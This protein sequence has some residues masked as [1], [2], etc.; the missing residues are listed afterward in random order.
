MNASLNASLNDTS[1]SFQ[2]VPVWLR[3]IHGVV[4]S[5]LMLAAVIGNSLVLFL[6]LHNKTLQHRSVMCSLGLVVAD[7]LIAVAWST[8]TLGNIGLD[9]CP[10]GPIGCSILGVLT[11]IGVYARWCTVALITLERFLSIVFP[12]WYLKRS[13][14]VLVVLTIICWL[15]PIASTT[16]PWLAGLGSYAFR[17]QYSSCI[18]TCSE[19]DHLCFRFYLSLYGIYIGV[20]GVLPMILYLLMCVIGQRKLYKMKHIELGTHKNGTSRGGGK[21]KHS[22]VAIREEKQDDNPHGNGQTKTDHK[23]STEIRKKVTPSSPTTPRRGIMALD[24]K[25]LKTFFMIFMN[26]FLTQLPIY[27]TSALR[28]NEQIFDEI[29]DPVHFVF[30][31]IYLLG[32][33]LDPL[34]IMRNKDFGDT[35][36]RIWRRRAASVQNSNVTQALM[37]FVKMSSLIDVGPENSNR[38]RMRRN[39]CPTV[40]MHRVAP[41]E[42][43]IVKARSLDGCV[44]WDK[45]INPPLN[46]ASLGKN[47]TRSE[48]NQ[49]GRETRSLGREPRG[50]HICVEES[51]LLTVEALSKV[52]ELEEPPPE[53]GQREVPRA[54]DER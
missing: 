10:F 38:L 1:E 26:V 50:V 21:I 54:V 11:S 35:F 22:R 43:P 17:V 12:F 3:S 6:V 44:S 40:T 25:I 52:C 39:S 31:Y 5:L 42:Q 14:V 53:E 9:H 33:V 19:I 18:I 41:L 51:N 45:E 4:L 28:S 20:G 47:L 32:P 24:K 23:N 37:D 46:L 29:P 34:L 36:K 13:K 16:I 27:I 2:E 15:V 48:N 30:T 8:Q 7:M 49:V